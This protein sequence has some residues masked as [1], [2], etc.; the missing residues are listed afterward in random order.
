MSDAEDS[1][2]RANQRYSL[3]RDQYR[4]TAT[5]EATT[6]GT[7]NSRLDKYFKYSLIKRKRDAF[8]DKKGAIESNDEYSPPVDF[9][10]NEENQIAENDSDTSSYTGRGSSYRK[11]HKTKKRK[12][13]RI[14]K[15]LIKKR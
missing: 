10:S 4:E 14:N 8:V 3:L 1:P 6:S 11:T 13:G 9:S 12:S 2:K 7:R 15:K 5:E